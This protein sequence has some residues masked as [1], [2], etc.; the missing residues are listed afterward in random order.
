M[1]ITTYNIKYNKIIFEFAKMGYTQKEIC[2]ALSITVQGLQKWFARYP[3]FR[4]AW[5]DG[6]NTTQNII[7]Y[8]KK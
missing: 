4:I 5:Q 8:R 1:N 6:K 7:F 3:D 2:N